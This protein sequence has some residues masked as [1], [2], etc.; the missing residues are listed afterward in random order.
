MRFRLFQ[1]RGNNE[2]RWRCVRLPRPS[3][4]AL[5]LPLAVAAHPSSRNSKPETRN[6]YLI[7]LVAASRQL[8]LREV[9]LLHVE[10]IAG[11]CDALGRIFLRLRRGNDHRFARLPVR[12]SSASIRVGGLQRLEDTQDLVD[13]A[14]SDKG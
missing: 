1:G 5:A 8:L 6:G 4:L 10:S 13:V 12:R 14:P 7:P 11:G 2:P 3:R 9:P